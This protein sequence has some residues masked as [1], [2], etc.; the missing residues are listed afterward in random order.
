MVKNFFFVFF[1]ELNVQTIQCSYPPLRG[2]NVNFG[3]FEGFNL[4]I[5]VSSTIDF[6]VGLN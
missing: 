5:L 4:K 3:I 1:L 2:E 6:K